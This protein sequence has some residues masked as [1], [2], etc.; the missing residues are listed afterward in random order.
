VGGGAPVSVAISLASP[1]PAEGLTFTLSS[2]SSAI[3]L[4]ASIAIP[5][6]STAVSFLAT[7]N[8]VDY[9]TDAIVT[10]VSPSVTVTNTMVVDP[11]LSGIEL[12]VTS[13]QGGQPVQATLYLNKSAPLGGLTVQLSSDTPN[14]ATLPASLTV[15]AGLSAVNF[16]ITTYPV[17]GG[18][19]VTLT[20]SYGGSAPQVSLTVTP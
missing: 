8:A 6:G 19:T 5:G 4:P 16:T 10:A 17:S 3:T 13:V 11:L 14:V 7:A 12:P 20:S 18:A 1:A 15:P 9:S 2:N